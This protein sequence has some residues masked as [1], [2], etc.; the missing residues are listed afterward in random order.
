MSQG[1]LR[2]VLASTSPRRRRLLTEAG[3]EFQV[4]APEVPELHTDDFT[5]R[6][7]TCG[8]ASRKGLAVARRFPNSIVL[9]ADTLVALD[10]KLIGKPAN[11]SAAV[12]LLWLLSGRTHQV[13][14]GVFLIH[15]RQRKSVVFSVLSQVIF[16]ELTASIIKNYLARINPL[17]KAGGYAAQGGGSEIIER[18]IGSR[19]NVIGLPLEETER[20]LRN[21]GLRPAARA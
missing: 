14:T 8:N 15:A 16:H 11:R 7:I 5:L 9:A 17:D 13:A 2:L 12:D 18:I 4:C 19:S 1:G 20:A 21:F 3:Y 10:Q 6:E